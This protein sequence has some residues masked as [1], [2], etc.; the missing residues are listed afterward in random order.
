MSVEAINLAAEEQKEIDYQVDEWLRKMG[1][2]DDHFVIDSRLAFHW[3][4]ESF[5]VYLTLD[6]D[7]A[8]GRIF[9]HMKDAGRVSEDATTVEEVRT[10]IE[11][12]YASE[13]KRY[14]D[15]YNVDPSDTSHF[16]L[17][18]DTN[19]HDLPTVIRMVVDAYN[20]WRT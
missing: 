6:P 8:A 7:T 11:R 20:A 17:V 2:E 15:L 4:P 3:I 14:L 18:I 10:S 5:K 13:Q 1:R 12:R 16:D 9:K 19:A